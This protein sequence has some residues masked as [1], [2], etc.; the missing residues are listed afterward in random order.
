MILH[1]F[2]KSCSVI[3]KLKL[4][5]I[6][7]Y[8]NKGTSKYY[9][10]YAELKKS[11]VNKKLVRKTGELYHVQNNLHCKQKGGVAK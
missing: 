11:N 7:L 4:G 1:G 6:G 3:L 8:S 5:I 9:R 2:R 10:A